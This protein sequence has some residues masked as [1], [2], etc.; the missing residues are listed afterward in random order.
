M[1]DK[2]IEIFVLQ[3]MD[4]STVFNAINQD[5]A[6]IGAENST[7]HSVAIST[8]ACPDDPLS[9]VVRDLSPGQLSAY[10]V[11]DPAKMVFTSFAGSIGSLAVTAMPLP[12]D[13]CAVAPM[14]VSQCNGVFNDL[15]P[16]NL[17]CVTD[18]LSST[19][20]VAEKATTILQS[21]GSVAPELV[22]KRG[23]Y[24][25]GN[26]GDTLYTWLYPPNAYRHVVPWRFC[27]VVRLGVQPASGR[28]QRPH[29]RW[30]RAFYQGYR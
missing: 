15:A 26:W 13:G 6:I 16:I 14:L 18:G 20:F 3:Y 1:V 4:Q 19:M 21:L 29:G 17:A 12:S 11:A 27:R 5:L 9:G 28:R 7:V 8:L 24:V 25:T 2:S 23:W 10:G 30:L 22:A